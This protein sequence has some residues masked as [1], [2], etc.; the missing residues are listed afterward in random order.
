MIN[1]DVV[2]FGGGIFPDEDIPRLKELG[3]SEVFRPEREWKIG[4][5]SHRVLQPRFRRNWSSLS[6]HPGLS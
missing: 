2:V 6:R 1:N 3:V 5:N 4:N